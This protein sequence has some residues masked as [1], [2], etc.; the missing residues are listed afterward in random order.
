MAVISCPHCRAINEIS[1]SDCLDN[2]SIFTCQGCGRQ[3]TVWLFTSA[4]LE[5]INTAVAQLSV[6]KP[7]CSDPSADYGPNED[8]QE[9]P[10]PLPDAPPID[11]FAPMSPSSIYS[12]DIR[13]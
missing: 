9:N 10:G 11:P 8:R 1:G 13:Y 2:G 3:F 12:P 6:F 4:Q 7:H 5:K